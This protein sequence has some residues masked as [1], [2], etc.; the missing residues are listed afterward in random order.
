ME[1]RRLKKMISDLEKQIQQPNSNTNGGFLGNLMGNKPKLPTNDYKR[2]KVNNTPRRDNGRGYVGGNRDRPR[3][4][5]D[6]EN[7]QR[8]GNE[9]FNGS[10]GALGDS[11]VLGKFRQDLT[12]ATKNNSNC[13]IF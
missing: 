13:N 7:F 9:N 3:V 2:V 5:S 1:K 10:G 12:G 11:S 8:N 6:V 4:L